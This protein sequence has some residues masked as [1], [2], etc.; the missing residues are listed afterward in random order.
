MSDMFHGLSIHRCCSLAFELATRNNI[1]VPLSWQINKKAGHDWWLGFKQRYELSVRKPEA[2]SLGRATAFNKPVVSK[3][4]DN[5]A[6]VMDKFKFS[7]SDIYNLDETGCTTVQRPLS[8]I[9]QRGKKQVGAITSAERGEL[10]TVVYTVSAIGTVVPPLF[11]FPRVNFKEHFTRGG[12]TD[13]IGRASR[14]GWML[15]D[16]FVEYL[17]HLVKHT[18]CSTDKKIL[19]IMDNHDTHI[20]LEAIDT[21]KANGIVLLTIPPHT[22]HRLQPLDCSVYG[23]F[24]S[25]YN[26]ALD[27]WVRSNPGK[28]VSIYEIPALVNQAQMVAVTAANIVAGF[29]V[30]GISPFNSD[31]F[32]DSDFASAAPTD[33][34]EEDDVLDNDETQA[35]NSVTDV[36]V[37]QASTSTNNESS[38]YVSPCDIQPFPKAVR[39]KNTKGRKKGST[40]ILTSTPELNQLQAVGNTK[41]RKKSTKIE[42]SSKR[43]LFK[44]KSYVL[45]HLIVP[46]MKI[47]QKWSVMITQM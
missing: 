36:T 10:V 26:R 32:P 29:R 28:T 43:C 38:G 39:R 35:R 33:Q 15:A 40:K 34:P 22:S 24:K 16:I 6:E 14:S 23:P 31:V 18:K 44:K 2:T 13:C 41:K 37:A 47:V 5:L 42:T 21:A 12:P 1:D 3:F 25:A 27:G 4:F 20:S 7:P 8:V 46:V 19:L 45:C 17:K 9:T 30:T 11:I